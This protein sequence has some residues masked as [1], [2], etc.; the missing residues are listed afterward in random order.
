MRTVIVGAGVVGTALAEQ[1]SREGHQ[2]SV[3]ERD[4]HIVSELADKFD[5]LTLHG[6]AC[7]DR[8]LHRAGIKHADM[9]IAVTNVDEVNI[10]LGM[11]AERMKVPR[12]II[13]VR[14]KE[15]GKFSGML[16]LADFGI[17]DVINPEPVV[18]DSLM[19]MIEIP[20]CNDYYSFADGQVQVLGFSVAP[21]SP[22]CGQTVADLRQVGDLNAFLILYINRLDKLLIPKGNTVLEAGDIVHILVSAETVDF[23][24][25]IVHRTPPRND[26]VLIVGASRIGM[27]LAES[28][29]GHVKRLI[30]IES[31]P[32][33]ARE[34]AIRL[35]KSTVLHGDA[36]DLEVLMEASIERCDLFCAVTDDDQDNMLSSL[37][38]KRHSS[39][40]TAVLVY[41]P[42]Y[43]AVL[44]RL[45]VERVI[46]PRLVTV[47]EILRHVRKGRIHSVTRVADS[48]AEILEMEAQVGSRIVGG[49]LK[50]I[51]FPKGAIVGGV[52]ADGIMQIPTGETRILP[53]QRVFVFVLD[54]EIKAIEKLFG[55]Y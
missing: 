5:I 41:H 45:G 11:I 50:D 10:V 21:D 42:E 26:H 32:E 36:T 18:V 30:L 8:L 40:R 43:V 17:H 12:R 6:D 9:L 23:L 31:D 46:N 48:H 47:S 19:R 54:K 53:G 37:L 1:F 51:R 27:A 38:A 28:L 2:V 25:P 7:S 13:R 20:G 15:F 33:R 49:P 44:D 24:L 52:L 4:R 55:A 29:E 14:N 3:I 39:A 35:E 34:A 16:P 22:M